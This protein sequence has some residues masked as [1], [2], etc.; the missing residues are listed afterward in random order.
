M[1]CVCVPSL[2]FKSSNIYV[3]DKQ[4]KIT[5]NKLSMSLSVT[6]LHINDFTHEFISKLLPC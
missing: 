6:I 1:V 3:V 4:T 5:P 2:K